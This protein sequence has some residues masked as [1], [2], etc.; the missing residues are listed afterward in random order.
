ML[1][2]AEQLLGRPDE[3]LRLCDEALR[4]ASQLKNPDDLVYALVQAATA[5]SR[6]REPDAARELAEAARAVAEKNGFLRGVAK[7]VMGWAKAEL[8]Q[9]EQALAELE[10]QGDSTMFFDGEILRAQGYIRVGR[11]E[12]ALEM[13]NQHLA[14]LERFGARQNE[15]E[16]YRLKGE[17]ILMRDSSATAEAE[18]CFRKAIEIARS[19]S[20]KWWEL[21]A[22]NSLARLLRDTN[23]R[24]EARGMLAEIYKWFTEGFDTA[25]L[26]DA[27]RLLDELSS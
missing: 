13:L 19:Q 12:Q 10:P 7:A 16:V 26:K 20:A 18:A 3:A 27:K 21:R 25:D 1:G 5:R 8:G 14:Q 2:I 9:T 4:R 11:I 24:D 15:P 6:R 23:R 17:A 22:T